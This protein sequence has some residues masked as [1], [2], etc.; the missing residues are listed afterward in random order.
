MRK[1]GG[2]DEPKGFRLSICKAG[3][4][5]NG[6]EEGILGEADL[7]G[8]IRSLISTCNFDVTS[9]HAVGCTT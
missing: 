5:V 4:A 6:N 8:K 2:E 3:I 1:K 7:G 9:R